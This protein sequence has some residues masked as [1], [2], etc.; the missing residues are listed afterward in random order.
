MSEEQK[1]K[2]YR[3]LQV[4][5]FLIAWILLT[6]IF[7]KYGEL[8]GITVAVVAV[9]GAAVVAVAGAAVVAAVAVVAVAVVAVAGASGAVAVAGAAGA[10]AVAGA[11]GAVY[12]IEIII[13]GFLQL[14]IE[15]LGK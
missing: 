8:E 2:L 4:I 5:T 15:K 13:I 6:I 3:T 12:F 9:A 1:I 10:V 14:K 11:V 7:I